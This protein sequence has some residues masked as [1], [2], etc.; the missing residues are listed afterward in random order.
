MVEAAWVRWLVGF[1]APNRTCP[2]G[3]FGGPWKSAMA[4]MGFGLGMLGLF[5][6]WLA[7]SLSDLGTMVFRIDYL[8]DASKP[9]TS[10]PSFSKIFSAILMNLF[11]RSM[12][13]RIRAPDANRV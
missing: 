7:C 5:M 13:D 6:S 2:W 10:G 3:F 1:F 12:S 9:P 4:C 11:Q 8:H